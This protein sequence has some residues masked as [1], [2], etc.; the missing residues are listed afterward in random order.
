MLLIILSAHAAAYETAAEQKETP[1]VGNRKR[2]QRE[3]EG[4]KKWLA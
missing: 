3:R 4:K 1:T 2:E